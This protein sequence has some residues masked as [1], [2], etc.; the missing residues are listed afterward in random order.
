MV[1]GASSPVG[2]AV[3]MDCSGQHGHQVVDRDIGR[4]SNIQVLRVRDGKIV[5]TRDFHNHAALV[6]A[7]T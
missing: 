5:A 7:M 1:L 6:A 3:G 2:V 4:V